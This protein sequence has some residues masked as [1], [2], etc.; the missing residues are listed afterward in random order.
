MRYVWWMNETVARMWQSHQSSKECRAFRR[1]RCQCE[2]KPTSFRWYQTIWWKCCVQRTH[3]HHTV[4][5]TVRT[6]GNNER[7]HWHHIFHLIWRFFRDSLKGTQ[8]RRL[9]TSFIFES[10]FSFSFFVRI[11]FWS[12]L[13]KC[14]TVT[15]GQY[16]FERA[17][18][19]SFLL[20]EQK[21]FVN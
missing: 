15:H 2:S 1:C 3:A 5:D 16:I 6:V 11:L 17:F 8:Y 10:N 12:N 13:N 14:V 21:K 9:A 4:S 18:D 7:T 20:S 19:V